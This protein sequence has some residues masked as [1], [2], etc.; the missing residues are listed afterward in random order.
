[1][2]EPGAWTGAPVV[3]T[4]Y[5]AIQGREDADRTLVW[6]GVP[7]ARPPVGELRWRAPQDPLP[8]AG[9]R[10]TSRFNGGCTQFS[11]VFA[12]SISGSEDCLY[13]NVWRPQGADTGLPVYVWI[14]GGGNSIGSA[15]MVPDYY[16]NRI[17]A[18]ER[19][20]FVS[21]NYRLGPFGWFT[22]PALR[23]GAS[24]EDASGN[25]GTL[26]IIQALKWIRENIAAFGGDPGS[27]T[28]AGQSAG[29]TNVLSLMIAPPARGLFHRAISQSGSAATR[30]IEEADGKA[31]GILETLLV[32]DGSART[33]EAAA[34]MAASMSPDRIRAYLRSRTDRQILRTYRSPGLGMIDNPAILR[35]GVVI[36]RE[37]FDVL[38]TGDYPSKVPLIIGS[39]REELKLF[40]LFSGSIPWRSDLYKAVAKY[41][42]A[43]WKASGV[44]E[45]AR[46][47]ATHADQPGVYA[48]EFSWGA[49]DPNGVSPLPGT[50]GQRL[51][52]FH[53]LEIPFFLGTDTLEGALQLIL[54]T[55]QNEPGRKA[56]SNA[57]MSYVGSFARTGNPNAPQS[58]L[59]A[60][61][62]WSNDPG[63]PRCIVFDVRGDVPAIVM[64]DRE[65]TDDG[66]IATLKAE[67]PAELA[68]QTLENLA[69]SHTSS[70]VR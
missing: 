33:R 45:V 27:V 14:H 59:P 40:L 48:F 43:R 4:R 22:H 69:K 31:V 67:L 13:L 30:G 12:G 34:A 8:W 68:R 18:R 3:T 44:D 54:F 11:P 17:A 32:S 16:G 2:R 9:V 25:Y 50:W 28:I 66:V 61:E 19:L 38:T 65:L 36:P 7:Y 56:L 29:A 63:A 20:I 1:L 60:W 23:E 42:S 46:R 64:T 5:G 39:N 10:D 26:D 35:D 52:A 70:R 49:P 62:P 53:S 24:A 6:K 55:R 15:T 47:L 51:G 21:I 58:G 37:G 57:M 41:G